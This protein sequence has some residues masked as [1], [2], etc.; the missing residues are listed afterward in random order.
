LSPWLRYLILVRVQSGT[1]HQSFH[2]STR[3]VLAI[4]MYGTSLIG[5]VEPGY[6]QPTFRTTL[7]SRKLA[8]VIR[9]LLSWCIFSTPRCSPARG[10]AQE[11]S[12][13]MEYAHSIFASHHLASSTVCPH[14][15]TLAPDSDNKTFTRCECATATYVMRLSTILALAGL[16]V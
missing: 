11:R 8:E 12:L 10:W 16:S 14:W 9:A 4:N 6:P 1:M 7:N 3:I 13:I 2:S 15:D 5:R